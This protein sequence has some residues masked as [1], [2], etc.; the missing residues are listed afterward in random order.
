MKVISGFIQRHST[1]WSANSWQPS[2]AIMRTIKL[3]S[4]WSLCLQLLFLL[5]LLGC[6]GLDSANIQTFSQG[7]VAAKHQTDVSFKGVTDLTSKAIIA[8]AAEQ[9]TL[10]DANFFVVLSPEAM[11]AW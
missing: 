7:V 4:H 1:A 11:A 6:R 8:Y 9:P 10:K 5:L 3:I 2:S